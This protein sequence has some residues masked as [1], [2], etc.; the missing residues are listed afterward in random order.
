MSQSMYDIVRTGNL[1]VSHDGAERTFAT[2]LI[3][4][5]LDGK[6]DNAE[7]IIEHMK[8]SECFLGFLHLGIAQMIIRLRAIAR[9]AD[10]KG[11]KQPFDQPAGQKRLDSWAPKPVGQPTADPKQAANIAAIKAAA[12]PLL[13]MAGQTPEAV[14][15]IFANSFSQAEI[16][17]ALAEIATP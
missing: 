13:A 8:N 1:E 12:E 7:A 2:P 16:K 11:V 15:A 5:D 6:L 4:T 14:A 17:Q 9:P 10:V 3:L